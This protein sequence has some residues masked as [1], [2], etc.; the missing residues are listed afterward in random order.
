MEKK[1]TEIILQALKEEGVKYVFGYPGGCVIPLFD[2][3]LNHPEIEMIRVRHEQAAA[4]A[5]D[6]YARVSGR[7]AVVIATSGPGA[8]NTIT[9]IATAAL[10]SI[11]MVIITGQ[12][13]RKVIGTN[14]FQEINVLGISRPVTKHNYLVK[15]ITNL[16]RILKEAFYIAQ[17]G[18]PGPVLI[19]IPVDIQTQTTDVNIPAKIDIPGY[20]LPEKVSAED[21]HQV[22]DMIQHAS[23]P[24][25]YAG[26]GVNLTNAGAEL[27]EFAE[28]CNIPV[29]TTLLGLGCIPEDHELALGMLGMHGQYTANIAMTRTDLVIVLGARF[30]DRVTGKVET[31]LAQSKIIHVDI[32]PSVI[33]K[34]KE[35]NIGII[36]DVKDFLIG[37]NKLAGPLETELWVD[38]VKKT[39]KAHPLKNYDKEPMAENELRP[40][41]I[42]GQFSKYTKSEVV[43]VTDVGQHQMFVALYFKFKKA[44][45]HLSSGGLGTMGYSLPAS[46][47]AAYWVK[48]RR[49]ISFSGDGG[50]QMNIQELATIRNYNLPIII[51]VFNNGNLGMVKQW[52]DFFWNSRHSGTILDV[53]PDFVKVAEAYGIPGFRISKK[54][55][56]PELIK[57]ALKTK[58]PI[59]LEFVLDKD[60]HV[61]PMIPPGDEIKNIIE[62]AGQ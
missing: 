25:I 8:T 13:R 55:E 58:G 42:I 27:L 38:E 41:Y 50:F 32:D 37:L 33:N 46:I 31:F 62:G 3:F 54:K 56:V 17:T 4:H 61:Y 51:V 24:V 43:V 1:G 36:G 14:A 23:R 15:D 59:L 47:G 40:E 34:I 29:T 28:K 30:D 18:R 19:D 10:D 49:I 6:G 26:G 16:P 44:R 53:N 39:Q 21:L 5:A 45:S 22:W 11:P 2:E 7:A 9:G 60:A 48:N 57:K 35:A 52:Q 12:V 20:V